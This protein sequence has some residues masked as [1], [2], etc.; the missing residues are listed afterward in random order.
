VKNPPAWGGEPR[1]GKYLSYLP[2]ALYRKAAMASLVTIFDGLNVPS[3]YPV[4][5]P[6]SLNF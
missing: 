2:K 3:G 5:K 4:V 1:Q 6:N